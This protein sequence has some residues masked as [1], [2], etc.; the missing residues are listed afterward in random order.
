MAHR[1]VVD[2]GRVSVEV[3]V[4]QDVEPLARQVADHVQEARV[5]SGVGHV[6]VAG[7]AVEGGRRRDLQ[8]TSV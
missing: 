2:G 4:D 6:I 8:P 7:A 1:R 3:V 5:H